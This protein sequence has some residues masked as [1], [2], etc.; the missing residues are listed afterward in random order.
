MQIVPLTDLDRSLNFVPEKEL[1]ASLPVFAWRGM[2]LN[3]FGRGEGEAVQLESEFA[4]SFFQANPE[5]SL[6]EL[7]RLCAK[8]VASEVITESQLDQLL[9]RYQIKP[10]SQNKRL[11]A[12]FSKLPLEFQRW[13][14]S[15]NCNL[16]DLVVLLSVT[17][18]QVVEA[19]L[20]AIGQARPSLS[21][22]LQALELYVELQLMNK[23]PPLP[24]ESFEAWRKQLKALRYPL[25]QASQNLAHKLVKS[26]A[27][28]SRVQA[29]F[30]SKGDADILNLKLE[31]KSL[32]DFETKLHA[33]QKIQQ[34]MREK[35]PWG[36]NS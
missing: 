2:Q 19:G 13:S 5:L 28:P 33:I 32:E 21:S 35:N 18:L 15:K 26:F 36:G 1:A 11:L 9:A 10:S 3:G 12:L 24:S 27:W 22:G 14:S 17:D 25:R 16:G 4:E 20:L 31:I 34:E 29:N 6:A 8:I 23:M 30:S 7:A